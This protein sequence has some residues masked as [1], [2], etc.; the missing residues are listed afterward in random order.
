MARTIMKMCRVEKNPGKNGQSSQIY[1]GKNGVKY[2]ENMQSWKINPGKNCANYHE[3]VQTVW[4]LFKA[5]DFLNWLPQPRSHH[6]F[7][8]STPGRDL[9]IA[10]TSVYFS[11]LAPTSINLLIFTKNHLLSQNQRNQGV[12][13]NMKERKSFNK[14]FDFRNNKAGFIC[15]PK[16]LDVILNTKIKTPLI[17]GFPKCDLNCVCFH[18][19]GDIKFCPD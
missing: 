19:T 6:S 18:I 9:N 16:L 14:D 11:E 10:N 13:R 7:S 5:S 2:H 3:N 8:T 17:L 4:C 15:Q 12:P 1:T